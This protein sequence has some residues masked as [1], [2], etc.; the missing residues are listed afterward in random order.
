MS[1]T[2]LTDEAILKLAPGDSFTIVGRHQIAVC[3]VLSVR[4][5]SCCE[6][7]AIVAV[8]SPESV[9]AVVADMVGLPEDTKALEVDMEVLDRG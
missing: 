5:R 6:K 2:C 4:R 8:D 7:N 3:Q 9:K 1:K